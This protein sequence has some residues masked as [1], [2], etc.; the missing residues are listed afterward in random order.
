M[1]RRDLLRVAAAAAV[2]SVLPR[3]PML[4]PAPTID[5]LRVKIVETFGLPEGFAWYNSD[6]NAIGVARKPATDTEPAETDAA[7]RRRIVEA[8]S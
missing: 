1:K 5:D 6:T 7:L 8:L 4:A 2:G 3:P